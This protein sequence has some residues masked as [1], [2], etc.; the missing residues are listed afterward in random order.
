MIEKIKNKTDRLGFKIWEKY[1][2][3]IDSPLNKVT[4]NSK[5]LWGSYVTFDY[6][7]LIYM[8]KIIDIIYY[9]VCLII[10]CIDELKKY[11]TKPS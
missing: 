2:E 4:L 10:N 5:N 6:L 3:I 9:Y 7:I 1:F 11:S 8:H